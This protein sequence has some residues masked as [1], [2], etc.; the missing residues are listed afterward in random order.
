M[1][2]LTLHTLSVREEHECPH[3]TRYFLLE[4]NAREAMLREVRRLKTED[5]VIWD[6]N[7]GP[8]SWIGLQ[9]SGA[10]VFVTLQTKPF[11]DPYVQIYANEL[12]LY[13]R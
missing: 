7:S 9:P 2:F 3:I 1:P 6:E 8:D 4:V 11:D 13:S 5:K 12:T 10:K